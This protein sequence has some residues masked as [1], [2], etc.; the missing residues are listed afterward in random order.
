MQEFLEL[1]EDSPTTYN[2]VITNYAKLVGR[3][4]GKDAYFEATWGA[5]VLDEGHNIQNIR[6][7]LHKGCTKL[8]RTY[9]I[10]LTGTCLFI[11]TYIFF[12]VK[13]GSNCP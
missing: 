12:E 2:I 6:G 3:S 7:G 10:M 11:T 1:Q 9:S 13:F 4:S 5:V 8:K